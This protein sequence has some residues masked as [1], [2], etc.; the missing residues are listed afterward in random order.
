MEWQAWTG[1]QSLGD[2]L[3]STFQRLP[4][5]KWLIT[6]LGAQG[7]VFLQR[8]EVAAQSAAMPAAR[9]DDLLE[10][11]G[12]RLKVSEEPGD[13]SSPACTAANGEQI[14]CSHSPYTT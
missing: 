1:E 4:H 8:P 10:S 11:L 3:L 13:S 12:S 9:L 2:A 6:T 5:I 7:A 14:R